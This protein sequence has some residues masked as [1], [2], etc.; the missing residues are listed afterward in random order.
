MGFGMVIPILP[1]YIE[2][3]D[4]GGSSMGMLMAIYATMQFI[5]SPL[6]GRASDKYGRKPILLI[7]VLGNAL[8]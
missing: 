1:F 7:G 4:A 6:W 3:F 5:F 2:R 8:S